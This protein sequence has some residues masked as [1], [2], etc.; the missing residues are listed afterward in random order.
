MVVAMGSRRS[1]LYE[2]FSS[3]FPL[4]LVCRIVVIK[5]Y[6]ILVIMSS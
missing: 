5:N 1:T 2:Q 4:L 3:L 6:L